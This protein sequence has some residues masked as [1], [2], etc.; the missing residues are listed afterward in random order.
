MK[1]EAIKPIASGKYRL[2]TNKHKWKMWVG[3][4]VKKEG[5]QQVE[6]LLF[7]DKYYSWFSKKKKSRF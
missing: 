6:S 4:Y 3:L 1:Q 2:N 7:K 5:A